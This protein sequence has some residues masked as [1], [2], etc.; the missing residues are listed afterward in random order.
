MRCT[1]FLFTAMLLPSF[2]FKLNQISEPSDS[3][4]GPDPR[5]SD[6]SYFSEINV[7]EKSGCLA[8]I[9]VNYFNVAT[10]DA[11]TNTRG[12]NFVL[13]VKEGRQ[14]SSAPWKTLFN[15]TVSGTATTTTPTSEFAWKAGQVKLNDSVVTFRSM[16]IRKNYAATSVSAGDSIPANVTCSG[17]KTGT[18]GALERA[19]DSYTAEYN[20]PQAC[21]TSLDWTLLIFLLFVGGSGG[22][23]ALLLGTSALRRYNESRGRTSPEAIEFTIGG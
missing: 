7:L 14:S 19:Y 18:Q 11:P 6:Y 4:Q 20:A 5:P 10:A 23:V 3:C 1:F 17:S 16:M 21:A 9:S 22:L 8:E 13:L 2:A 15:E 12:Y